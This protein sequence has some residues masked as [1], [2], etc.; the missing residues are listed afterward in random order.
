MRPARSSDAARELRGVP[1]DCRRTRWRRCR[2]AGRSA[3]RK[4]TARA[5]A[6]ARAGAGPPPGARS[7]PRGC[8][9][10]AHA[11]SPRDVATLL[12]ASPATPVDAMNDAA[13]AVSPSLAAAT[14][15]LTSAVWLCV[16]AMNRAK[17]AASPAGG[18]IGFSRAISRFDSRPLGEARNAQRHPAPRSSTGARVL[19]SVRGRLAC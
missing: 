17:R 6:S 7:A 14:A 3:G 12:L 9:F 4:F 15:S 2:Y 19:R 18:T 10:L 13:R 16:W 11:V 1:P 8:L 5:K